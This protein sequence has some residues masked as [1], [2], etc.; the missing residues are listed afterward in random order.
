M[1]FNGFTE[2]SVECVRHGRLHG[3]AIGKLARKSSIWF[4]KIW[5]DF[6]FWLTSSDGFRELS[7]KNKCRINE[8]CSAVH[9]T[10]APDDLCRFGERYSTSGHVLK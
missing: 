9:I 4:L 2:T 8:R 5:E 7:V 1:M 10:Q 3:R 6:A